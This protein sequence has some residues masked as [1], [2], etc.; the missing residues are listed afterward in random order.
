VASVGVSGR[1]IFPREGV[2]QLYQT[3]DVTLPKPETQ[4]DIRAPALIYNIF[5]R[6]VRLT[7]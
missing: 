7:K 2:S 3:F 5:I 1:Q 4:I 6:C